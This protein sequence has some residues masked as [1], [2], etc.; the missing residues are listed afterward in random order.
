VAVSPRIY[1]QFPGITGE[2][3][4][5]AVEVSSLTFNGSGPTSE[6]HLLL[7]VSSA[8]P[9]LA[10]D[11]AL[12]KAFPSVTITH[13]PERIILLNAIIS[14]YRPADGISLPLQDALTLNYIPKTTPP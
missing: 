6:A 1:I 8:S 11:A 12:G 7:P 4:G 13:G 10:L 9:K 2:G 3:P 14:E 5:G